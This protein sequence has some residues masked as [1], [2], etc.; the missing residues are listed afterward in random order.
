VQYGHEDQWPVLIIHVF[1]V[2]KRLLSS[3]YCDQDS[4]M[5][6]WYLHRINVYIN[7]L[8]NRSVLLTYYV[9]ISICCSAV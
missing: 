6:A 8:W 3:L 7:G 1:G 9:T 4:E 5:L 2:G